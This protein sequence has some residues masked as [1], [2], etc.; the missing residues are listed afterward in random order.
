MVLLPTHPIQDYRRP[1]P[2]SQTLTLI[3]SCNRVSDTETQGLGG[4][5]GF[6]KAMFLG[7]RTSEDLWHSFSGFIVSGLILGYREPKVIEEGG[8]TLDEAF[9]LNHFVVKWGCNGFWELDQK[10]A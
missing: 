3:V 8:R 4:I 10:T 1:F 2:F 7:S 5:S 6:C 9:N